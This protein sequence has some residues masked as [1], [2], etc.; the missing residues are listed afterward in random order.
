MGSSCKYLAHSA[1]PYFLSTEDEFGP[2]NGTFLRL[3]VE[4][5]LVVCLL[6][7]KGFVQLVAAP[8][9]LVWVNAN[10]VQ[11]V[12]VPS[13]WFTTRWLQN[14]QIRTQNLADNSAILAKKK[15]QTKM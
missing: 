8:A 10:L 4:Q 12:C 1:Q 15:F 13:H 5:L 6:A 11:A 9:C 3:T 7:Q 14:R 2:T